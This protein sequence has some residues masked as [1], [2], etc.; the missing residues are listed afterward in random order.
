MVGL[1]SRRTELEEEFMI[2]KV[3]GCGDLGGGLKLNNRPEFGGGLTG[4]AG[5]VMMAIVEKPLGF[6]AKL[7]VFGEKVHASASLKPIGIWIGIVAVEL[8]ASISA[9]AV[10]CRYRD[11]VASDEWPRRTWTVRMSTP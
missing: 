4:N 1:Q 5:L 2:S 9:W 10:V 7:K 11:V 6:F 8:I 3:L